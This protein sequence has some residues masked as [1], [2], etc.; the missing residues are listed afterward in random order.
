MAET[1]FLSSAQPFYHDAFRRSNLCLSFYIHSTFREPAPSSTVRERVWLD[2]QMGGTPR[3]DSFSC[4][5]PKTAGTSQS[6]EQISRGATSPLGAGGFREERGQRQKQSGWELVENLAAL[7]SQWSGKQLIHTS[8]VR[9][10]PCPGVC[11][12]LTHGVLGGA[13]SL[14]GSRYTDCLRSQLL[15]VFPYF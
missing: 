2:T 3:R 15:P 4:K 9:N 10:T 1:I 12:L 8:S 7:C 14:E 5:A 6:Y 11:V 13:C